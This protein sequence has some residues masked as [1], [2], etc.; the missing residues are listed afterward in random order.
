M[1]CSQEVSIMGMGT[2]EKRIISV[3][4][5]AFC[6]SFVIIQTACSNVLPKEEA[7]LAVPLVT[8]AA[9]EYKTKAAALS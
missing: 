6:L 5:T 4:L 1:I 9:V 8:P 7:A 3:I 2:V